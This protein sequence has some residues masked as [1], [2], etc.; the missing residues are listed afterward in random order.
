MQKHGKYWRLQDWG[1][2]QFSLSGLLKLVLQLSGFALPWFGRRP[3]RQHLVQTHAFM[4]RRPPPV[5]VM[6]G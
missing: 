3:A 1:T 4:F 5:F 6:Q 2:P